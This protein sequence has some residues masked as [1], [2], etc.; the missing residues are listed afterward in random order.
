M[1][2]AA[3]HLTDG[4]TALWARVPVNLAGVSIEVTRHRPFRLL[5]TDPRYQRSLTYETCDPQR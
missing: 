3:R 1:R 4:R 5:F 2:R